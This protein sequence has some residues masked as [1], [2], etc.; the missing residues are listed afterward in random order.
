MMNLLI[1]LCFGVASAVALVIMWRMAE[2]LRKEVQ[3]RQNPPA[4]NN[5]S[6][7]DES[8][9]EASDDGERPKAGR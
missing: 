3:S 7:S 9:K 2:R 4:E 8:L 5:G 6:R 1:G